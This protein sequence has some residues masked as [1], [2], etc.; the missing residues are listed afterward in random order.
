MINHIRTLINERKYIVTLHA[1]TRMDEKG[2]FTEDLVNLISEGEIIEEYPESRPCPSVLMMGIVA[3][4]YCH[5]VTALCK[6]HLRIITVYWPD[7]DKWID[8]R[9]RKAN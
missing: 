7:E 3:G 8:H 9:M 2:I 5:V 4:N 1:R 6:N